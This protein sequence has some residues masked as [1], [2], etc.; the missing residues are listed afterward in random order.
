MQQHQMTHLLTLGSDL[1]AADTRGILHVWYNASSEGIKVGLESS[2]VPGSL[3]VH[4]LESLHSMREGT[5]AV[6]TTATGQP[7]VQ[8]STLECLRAPV[9]EQ[10]GVVVVDL[11]AH[12]VLAVLQG[13]SDLVSCLCAT[14]DGRLVTAGGKLD[15]KV[16][17]WDQSQWEG[18]DGAAGSAQLGGVAVV[19]D[20]AQE[21]KDPGYVLALAVVGDTKP[22][23]SLFTLAAARYNQVKI[24]M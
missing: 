5:A 9:S 10:G 14:P 3:V 23:S 22:G 16:K 15:A 6:S 11:K 17:V 2:L 12:V 7:L 1:I 4:C 19:Q 18:G 20:A 24:C 21:L 8:P 13:H